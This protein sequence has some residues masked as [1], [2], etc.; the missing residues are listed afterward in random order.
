MRHV[1]DSFQLTVANIVPSLLLMPCN[2]STPYYSVLLFN[3]V[4]GNAT[5]DINV[6][7][8]S[9]RISVYAILL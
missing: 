4:S 2:S 7:L 6:Y 1:R 9:S 3:D 5:R 8:N